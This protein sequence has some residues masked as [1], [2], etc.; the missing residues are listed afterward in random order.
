ML[1]RANQIPTETKSNVRDGKGE[2]FFEYL[3]TPEE[4]YDHA[5]TF[6]RV[7]L[8]PGSSI[9]KH[10]HINNEEIYY[11]ISGTAT[12]TDDDQVYS[13]YPG[14]LVICP[15]QHYHGIANDTNENVV[16]IAEIVNK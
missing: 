9:G 13:I 6:C 15:D 11:M 5:S 8:Y 3:A 7:T 4:M 14:D 1:K 10:Q 2:I 12:Y 16:F